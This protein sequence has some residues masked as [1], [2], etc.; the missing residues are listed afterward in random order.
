MSK[1]CA[2][3]GADVNLFQTQKL[4]DGSRICR[5][6]CRRLGLPS[7]EYEHADLARVRAHHAE[8]ALGG[9]LWEQF[10][11][12]RMEETYNELR[13]LKRFGKSVYVSKE[14]GLAALKEN[15]YKYLFWGKTEHVCV[16][17]IADLRMYDF[18]KVVTATKKTTKVRYFIRFYFRNIDGLYTFRKQFSRKKCISI[19]GY[20][21]D[22]FGL[23]TVN[24]WDEK[25]S[26]NL[27]GDIKDIIAMAKAAKEAGIQPGC[28]NIT[29]EEL[30]RIMVKAGK[31]KEGDHTMR[32]AMEE[33]TSPTDRNKLTPDE[34]ERIMAKAGK[35]KEGDRRKWID[36][37]DATFSK[38]RN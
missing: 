23:E 4:G 9:K 14:I 35:I 28:T 15:R 19:I 36:K 20:F 11:V 21:D 29:P 17:R 8:A 34:F 16:Y 38:F 24:T 32:L 30:E 25:K 12:P 10:F 37:A 27:I 1:K 18:E 26:G 7:F 22:L 13:K 2:I 5:K 31:I 3:C 6:T 33:R